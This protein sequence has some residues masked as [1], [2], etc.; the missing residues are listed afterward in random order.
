MLKSP[1]IDGET[2]AWKSKQTSHMIEKR[3]ALWVAELPLPDCASAPEGE[4]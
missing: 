2:K 1:F 3:E 4:C